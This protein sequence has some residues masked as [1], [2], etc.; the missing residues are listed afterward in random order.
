MLTATAVLIPVTLVALIIS[1]AMTRRLPVMPV[2]TAGMVLVF[3]ALTLWLQDKTFIEIKLTV[4]YCLFGAAL[5]GSMAFGKLLLPIVLDTAFHLD[6]AGLAQ[7]DGA[8]GNV[9]FRTRGGQ[10]SSAPRADWDQWVAFKTFGVLPITLA[11]AWRRRLSSCVT[12]R[13]KMHFPTKCEAVVTTAR[14]LKATGPGGGSPGFGPCL[15]S[16]S[17]SSTRSSDA[18]LES[19]LS[20]GHSVSAS[21]PAFVAQ[22]QGR[23]RNLYRRQRHRLSAF[24]SQPDDLERVQRLF[25]HHAGGDIKGLHHGIAQVSSRALSEPQLE[26]ASQRAAELDVVFACRQP[27]RRAGEQNGL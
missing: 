4:I 2:V 16:R 18:S 21:R 25:D 6:A 13:K 22:A 9:L 10:R 24:G 26:R 11:F 19:A 5:L 23:A 20:S 14:S 27:K 8:L 3:G 15:S 7:T 12:R 17:P 1:F